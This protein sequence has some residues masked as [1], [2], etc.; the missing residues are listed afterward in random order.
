MYALVVPL[1]FRPGFRE[2]FLRVYQGHAVPDL[3]Q[4]RGFGGALVLTEADRDTG[5]LLSLWDSQTDVLKSQS[6]SRRILSAM[7]LP[8]L[9]QTPALEVFEVCVQSGQYV[10]GT[11][12]RILTLPVAGEQ[13]DDVLAI[14]HRELLPELK[15]QKG[16]QGVFWLADR[17]AGTGYGVTMWTTPDTM[18]AAD[19]SG[20][21]FP[22]AAAK[23]ALFFRQPPAVRYYTVSSQ[24]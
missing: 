5:V 7:L 18:R 4:R 6:H 15:R 16:F 3:L 2:G 22:S 17:V 13:L 24:L 19:A 11:A 20:G 9:A 21:F 14:Y 23:L 8:F 10:G 1:Q 12:A